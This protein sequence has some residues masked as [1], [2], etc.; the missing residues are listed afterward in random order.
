MKKKNEF[1]RVAH[2]TQRTR[3]RAHDGPWC[4]PREASLQRE[5]A[6]GGGISRTLVI[7]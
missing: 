1:S 6:R 5:T 2:A 7:L 3:A 4:G